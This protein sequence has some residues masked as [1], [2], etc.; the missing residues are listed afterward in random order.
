MRQSILTL[1]LFLLVLLDL[2]GSAA[3]GTSIEQT[4]AGTILLG[5]TREFAGFDTSASSAG[6][7][8]V[9]SR[10]VD[11]LPALAKLSV[12]RSY[13]GLRPYCEIGHPIIGPAPGRPDV[14]IAAGH[15]GDGIALAPIT[16][17]LVAD[18]ASG[19]ATRSDEDGDT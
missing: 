19:T 12:I 7:Q 5:S 9:L 4:R 16:G 2:T 18:W 15:E 3:A 8:S 17:R 1:A 10:A 14:F 13:A 6:M 11:V